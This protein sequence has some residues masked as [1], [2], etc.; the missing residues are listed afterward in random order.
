[1][2][3]RERG[4]SLLELVLV[5][6]LFGTLGAT[7]APL[8]RQG[9]QAYLTGRDIAETDWQARV[10][11]E[12]M[13]RELRAIRAPA[14]LTAASAS[15]ITFVDIDGDSIRYCQGGVGGCPG[16]AGEL[17]RNGA[18]LASGIGA[19]AFSFLSRAAGA[20]G[21]PASAFYVSVTFTATQNDVTKSYR[22]TVSPRNFP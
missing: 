10:A 17:M 7:A 20:T 14:D 22:T 19:L 6:V 3:A 21:A 5:I 8:L 12:R 4:F 13:T 16:A 18:P 2:R 9:L 15:D 1:M 11:T